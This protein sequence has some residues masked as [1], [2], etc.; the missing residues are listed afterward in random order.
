MFQDAWRLELAANSREAAVKWDTLRSSLLAMPVPGGMVGG[1]TMAEVAGNS[2][3]S[4]QVV[5]GYD[6][7]ARS[8]DF[9]WENDQTYTEALV[10]FVRYRAQLTREKAGGSK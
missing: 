6:L 7:R 1:P 2:S 5:M 4:L 8:T 3:K 10:W 9:A